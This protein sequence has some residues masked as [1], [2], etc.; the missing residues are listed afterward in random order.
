MTH[1][2][3]ISLIDTKKF[4]IYEL[5]SRLY[6]QVHLALV[7][8]QNSDKTVNIGV[9]FPEY[10]YREEKNTTFSGL[11]GKLRIFAQS[12]EELESV[13]LNTW[14]NRLTDYMDISSI[15][16]VPSNGV[17]HIIVSNYVKPKN[18]SSVTKRFMKRESERLGRELSFSEAKQLQHQRFAE[19]NA[20][21]L[22]EAEKHYKNPQVLNF[23]YIKLKSLSNKNTFTLR[24]RQKQVAEKI[25]GSFNTYGLSSTTTVP[26]WS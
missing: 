23:P 7:E 3:E 16:E 1:Y 4:N 22:E 26:H 21:S 25:E 13:S 6:T 14:L 18:L 19:K 10:F 11:G 5:W 2:I 20:V 9:S 8:Q 12:K 24:I 17:Y 15:Q